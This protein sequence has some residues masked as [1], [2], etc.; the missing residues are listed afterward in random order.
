MTI[1]FNRDTFKT[2]RLNCLE[3]LAVVAREVAEYNATLGPE[4]VPMSK[5]FEMRSA[6]A[7][8]ATGF[9]ALIAIPAG[10]GRE[11]RG[12]RWRVAGSF[13][14]LDNGH[15]FDCGEKQRLQVGEDSWRKVAVLVTVLKS[16]VPSQYRS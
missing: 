1:E 13:S 5:R 12:G 6:K 10:S 4:L 8:F 15:L 9:W 14:L 2:I 16:T 7:A 3:C 11:P